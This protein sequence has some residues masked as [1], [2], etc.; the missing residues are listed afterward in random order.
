MKLYKNASGK[1]MLKISK[2]E[3]ENIGTS[4]GWLKKEAQT[5]MD[6]AMAEMAASFGPSVDD[7]VQEYAQRVVD[8][9]KGGQDAQQT[10][11]QLQV[12]QVM[13]KPVADLA[14]SMLNP[15]QATKPYDDNTPIPGSPNDNIQ[16]IPAR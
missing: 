1:D 11:E 2:T 7:K 13:R 14:M 4:N 15:Q 8:A 9:V 10:F 12:P 3:W 5:G 6:Q 16:A